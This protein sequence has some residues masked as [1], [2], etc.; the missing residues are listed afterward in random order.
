M[1]DSNLSRQDAR[2]LRRQ[3]AGKLNHQDANSAKA[4]SWGTCGVRNPVQENVH[5]FAVG[6]KPGQKL[7]Q[8][9]GV[10]AV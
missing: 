6:N 10:L 9:L 8:V 2:E 4:T 3:G 7:K 1:S 5:R